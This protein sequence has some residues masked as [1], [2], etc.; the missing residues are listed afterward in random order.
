MRPAL[1]FTLAFVL[2]SLPIPHAW[3]QSF[4]VDPSFNGGVALEDRFAGASTNSY[5]GRQLVR[6]ADT[7]I[8]VAGIVP[9]AF[10]AGSGN[11]GLVR[12]GPAGERLA[13]P[14]PPP[15]YIS[16]FDRYITFPNSTAAT[17]SRVDDLDAAGGFLFILA[18][19]GPASARDVDII[20]FTD[21]GGYVGTVAGFASNFDETGAG[22]MAYGQPGGALRV[23]AVASYR[24]SVSGRTIITARRYQVA[25]NGTLSVDNAFGPFGSGI[26][27][28]PMPDGACDA[29]TACSG[30]ARAT[31]AVRTNTASPTLYVGGY[32][33][34]AGLVPGR[35]RMLILAIDGASGL[36][37]PSF[38]RIANGI[39]VEN[40]ALVSFNAIVAR[41][42]GAPAADAVYIAAGIPT[43]AGQAQGRAVIR[44]LA[45]AGFPPPNE[46]TAIDQAWGSNGSRVLPAFCG[47]DIC[48]PS[49]REPFPLRAA[50]AGERLVVVGF[51][52]A[53]G[54]GI[55]EAL[56]SI[57]GPQGTLDTHQS[58]AAPRAGSGPWLGSALYDV[59]PREDG[60]VLATGVLHDSGPTQ[61]YGT[62]AYRVLPDM[63]Y[64]DGFE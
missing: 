60:T 6:L 22:L 59:A 46:G 36:A 61:L 44:Y 17:Y 8:V 10:Q 7:S 38:G 51:T 31:A 20:V 24:N 28:Y 9:A 64:A 21:S 47:G 58:I 18:T 35:E 41:D 1:R 42:G 25:G 40:T 45:Q 26:N 56:L 14:M 16:F 62:L 43:L 23:I 3:A 54:G 2:G 39:Y 4:G 48:G 49:R 33:S 57:L 32:A 11:V 30:L 37:S 13:W 15:P 55:P 5:F 19:R 29:G 50:L 52:E 34:S 27:D 63:L 12:Y 53:S